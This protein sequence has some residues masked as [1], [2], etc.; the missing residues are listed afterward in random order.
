[1][2]IS[3]IDAFKQAMIASQF[4]LQTAQGGAIGGARPVTPEKGPGAG[5]ENKT[6]AGFNWRNLN[7]Y[8]GKLTGSTPQIGFGKTSEK[9]IENIFA[10]GAGEKAAGTKS[11]EIGSAY[12]AQTN[13]LMATLNGI[14]AR[15]IGLNS[16]KNGFDGQKYINFLA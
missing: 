10:V 7:Q 12:K 3:G 9:P 5:T 14:D 2:A 11:P 15:D 13:N 16:N 6:T 1:M 8:D 4:G